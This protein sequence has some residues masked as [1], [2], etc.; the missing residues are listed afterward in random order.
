MLSLLPGYVGGCDP[1]MR[2]NR[3]NTTPRSTMRTGM[4]EV[5][6]LIPTGSTRFLTQGWVGYYFFLV[7]LGFNVLAYS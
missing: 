4:V 2:E 5:V 1:I 3:M 6:S 7:G